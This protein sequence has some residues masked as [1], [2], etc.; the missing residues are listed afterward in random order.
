MVQ[1][2]STRKA[3]RP[4]DRGY[5]KHKDKTMP[6]PPPFHVLPRYLNPALRSVAG[7]LP[8]LAL[9]H[10]RGRRSRRA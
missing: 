6:L 7:Y 9:L 3:A 10:H 1:C 8:P 2:S 5:T 4:D